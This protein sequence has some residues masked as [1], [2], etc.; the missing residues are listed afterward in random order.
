M[1]ELQFKSADGPIS[2]Q[3][4]APIKDSSNDCPWSIEVRTNGRK[5]TLRAEDPVEAMDHVA[6]FLGG[7]LSGRA[8]LDPA[9]ASLQSRSTDG[10]VRTRLAEHKKEL[11]ALTN[12][13][14][15]QTTR[16]RLHVVIQE[17]ETVLSVASRRPSA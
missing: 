14:E 17:L 11:A 10:I 13:N 15:D 4:G 5:Q 8:G 7:Y 3:V 16:E 12:S 1:I 6:T 2:I 9:V